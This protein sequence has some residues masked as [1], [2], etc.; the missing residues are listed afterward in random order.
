MVGWLCVF[1]G[2]YGVF[3]GCLEVLWTYPKLEISEDNGWVF[4]GVYVVYMWVFGGCLEVFWTY[5]KLEI[6]EPK[7][8]TR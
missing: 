2:V 6:S 8:M 7:S 4:M 3:G 1:M 5:P